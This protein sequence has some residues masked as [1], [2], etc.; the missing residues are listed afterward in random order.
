MKAYPSDLES[1]VQQM[2][3]VRDWPVIADHTL[4]GAAALPGT[5]YLGTAAITPAV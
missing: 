5:P 4:G 1:V 3:P 2:I